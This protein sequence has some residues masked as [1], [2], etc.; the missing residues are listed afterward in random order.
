MPVERLPSSWRGSTARSGCARSG[1]ARCGSRGTLR[2]ALAG[3][4]AEPRTTYVNV[5]FW[6]I[7]NVGPEAPQSPRNRA[8]E[9]KVSELDGHKSL[10]SEA[11]YDRGGLRPALRRGRPGP[12]QGAPRPRRPTDLPLRQGGATTMTSARSGSDRVDGCPSARPWTDWC[13]AGC[14]CA[15]RRTTAA[16][17]AAGRRRRACT[18]APSAGLAYLMTAP[19][20]LGLAR[21]YVSRRP[22]AHGRPPGRPVRRARAAQGP[23]AVP[24]AGA[25]P[26]R[27]RCPQPGPHPTCAPAPPPQEHLPRWRRAVEGLRHSMTRDAEVISHHYDVSNRFYEMVLGPSMAY[28]CAVYEPPDG[29]SRR[30]RRRSSTWSCRKL[31]LQPGP[32]AAR[33]RLRLGRRWCCTPPA[34]TAYARWA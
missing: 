5:G 6:G 3:L 20:D 23:H 21:A 28:T 30:R 13:A 7:V 19:G 31:D 24:G 26:R 8:I 17:P 4:P 33:R 29:P 25:R 22:R 15:S 11:F 1:C 2:P 9:A 18:C 27:R 32:A 12:G 16:A 14:R 34:S 10:Y